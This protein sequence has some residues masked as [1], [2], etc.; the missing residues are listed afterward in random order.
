MSRYIDTGGIE[1]TARYAWSAV[2]GG[3][4][5]TVRRFR[6]TFTLD[7][8]P[9][10]FLVHVTADSRY[11]LLVNGRRAGRGPLKGTLDH[12]FYETYDLASLLRPG[13]N[14][15]SA[16]VRWFGADSPTS[17]VH[18][19]LAGFLLQGPEAAGIGTPSGW[20]VLADQSVSAEKEGFVSNARNFL[21]HMDR[22][23]AAAH[24]RGWAEAEYD[25]AAWE[26]AVDA[27]AAGMTTV[28]GTYDRPRLFPREIEHLA[29]EPRDFV[30]TI[31]DHEPSPLPDGMWQTWEVA[32]GRDGELALD[33]GR[34]TTGYP[35]LAFDGGAGRRVELL[36][37]ES[38]FLPGDEPTKGIRDDTRH[39]DVVGYHDTVIL[40]GRPF[41]FESFHWR[42]FWFVKVRVSSGDTSFGLTD[43]GYR[44][45]SYP[46]PL[47][48]SFRAEGDGGDAEWFAWLMETGWR[49][50]R[51]CSH[52]TFE[53]C[54]YY[55]QLHYL[56]DSRLEALV[57]MY[58]S[59]DTDYVKR[60]LRLYRDSARWDG[61]VDSRTPSA[62]PQ[63]IPYFALLWV[64][65]LEDFW[66]FAG[67]SESDFIRSCLHAANG[68]LTY[69]RN[70]LRDDGFVGKVEVWNM[71]D[72]DDGWPRGEP[73]ALVEGESTY[74]TCLFIHAT[75]VLT[76]LHREVGDPDDAY[77]WER[78]SARLKPVV[79]E[80]AWSDS[81]GLF[82]EGP[83]RTEDALSQHC[84]IMAVLSGV[85]DE[86]QKTRIAERLTTDARLIRTKLMQS[87]YLA[88]G[89]AQLGRY[90]ELHAHVLEP[91]REMRSLHLSTLAEY[92]P[93]RSDCHA[94]SAWPLADFI[95]GILGIRPATPG[96][97]AISIAP[98][99]DG[100]DRAEGQ[101]TSP[102]G[103]IAVRWE[104]D[105]EG[106]VTVEAET[107]CGVP[108]T[109]AANGVV[110]E[111]PRGGVIRR[112][113]S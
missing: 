20:K 73:P 84:Q 5:L 103:T 44:C 16:E 74:L 99:T 7:S 113:G 50:L 22:V 79:R 104:K 9:Q 8:V 25:D 11:V 97:E 30:R 2:F 35:R 75:D 56:G 39:G 19:H 31:A 111:F 96:F 94:W 37:G 13:V 78:I 82:L 102:K 87:F 49:T 77:P 34:L 61:L 76:R 21:S 48:A 14:A 4:G 106:A 85:A 46:A 45:T 98:L 51:L 43:A 41:V 55:E 69:F 88:R 65:M 24:P 66:D 108:V 91:W 42:T 33:A 86:A 58:L 93:G 107:P 57:H 64:L 54:P 29:E 32:A 60:S 10:E 27:G 92:L 70:R 36:Y 28:W 101:M 81:E 15:L 59:G 47:Q 72:R 12:Y 63:T 6:R 105:A 89:L 83:G 62:S 67:P 80:R 109:V 52:E 1:W 38:M 100:L 90:G 110:R 112:Q 18:G 23:D 95:T 71:V 53:D 3:P 26:D 40:D 68:V 17:E